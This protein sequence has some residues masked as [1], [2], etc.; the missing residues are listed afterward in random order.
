MGRGSP[1]T[2][3]GRIGA[4]LRACLAAALAAGGLAAA[5]PDVIVPAAVNL[6]ILLI[7]EGPGDVTTAAW[8]AA[9]TS[10]GVPYTLATATGTAPSKT[11]DLAA[12]SS[13]GTGNYNGVVIAG[14]PAD[15]AGGALSALDSYESSLG[16]R[17]VDGYMFPSPALG[18]TEVTGGPLDGTT[19]T[20]TEAGLAAFPELKGP[21]PFDSGSYGYGATA[22]PRGALH[23]VPDRR[24]RSRHGRGL[25]APRRRPAGRGRRAG[26]Q[27]RLQRRP[28]P[29]AAAGPRAHQLGHRGHPPRPLPQLLRR[30]RRRC[31]IA[32]NEWSRQF[33]CTP[34]ATGPPDYTCPP[35]VAG[36]PADTPPDV[37]MSAADVAYVDA[38]EKQAGIRLNLAF[39]GLGACSADSAADESGSN[40][41]GSATDGGVTNTDPGQTVGPG[42]PDDAAFVNALLTD[43]GDFNWITHTWSHLFLGCTVWQPQALTSVTANALGG[44][45]AAGTYGYEVTAVTA[46][47]ESEPSP[48]RE[49][50]VLPSGSVTLTWP[51]AINGTSTDG[52]TP[53]PSLAHLLQRGELARRAERVQH[54]VRHPGRLARRP[55]LPGRH[56]AL[57]RHLGHPLPE[58]AG[59]R[60][61]RPGVRGPHH[62]GPRAR[63]QVAD[64]PQ[65]ERLHRPLPP[66]LGQQPDRLVAGQAGAQAPMAG[67]VLMQFAQDA[68][69]TARCACRGVEQE[70]DELAQ[71]P[72][73]RAA[74]AAGDRGGRRPPQRHRA[75]RDHVVRQRPHGKL[76]RRRHQGDEVE[77]VTGHPADELITPDAHPSEGERIGTFRNQCYIHMR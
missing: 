57:R 70:L 61:R 62:A 21:V 24:R 68:A 4:R 64:E 53:G 27:L 59:H 49:V 50:L 58:P 1:V 63:A 52:S 48:P 72:Q 36:N 31:F 34:A 19:G 26:A 39:N 35:G 77:V 17:Q 69:E 76:G 7:G 43:Q 25:P 29:V 6:R 45:L 13:G 20:L 18:V 66:R 41:T 74:P 51:E 47:G 42:N 12:L 32:D 55:R 15:Y 11:V 5:G 38:W 60:G 28:D 46:Y 56:R 14:S 54:P 65:V 40:C 23:A 3:Q 75:H 2:G 33:Q 30:G 67:G 8:Q 44:S 22:D 16:V 73:R 10:E 9:L 37:Q 71:Q